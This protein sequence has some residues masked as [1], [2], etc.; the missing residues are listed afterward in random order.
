M[1]AHLERFCSFS[2]P[3]ASP[4]LPF[5]RILRARKDL[6]MSFTF[7]LPAPSLDTHVDDQQRCY[8]RPAIRTDP[9]HPDMLYLEYGLKAQNYFD[10]TAFWRDWESIKLPGDV[11]S[12]SP[13]TTSDL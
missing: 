4:R 2:L 12:L 1:P 7:G 9:D 8:V 13:G 3:R 6:A 10:A 11:C 5:S